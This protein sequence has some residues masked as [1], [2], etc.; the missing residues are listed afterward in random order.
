[1]MIRMRMVLWPSETVYSGQEGD[2]YNIYL[3]KCHC[4]I[5]M[6]KYHATKMVTPPMMYINGHRVDKIGKENLTLFCTNKMS[7]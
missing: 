3:Y 4:W 2:K 6:M 1:M 5:S 7:F